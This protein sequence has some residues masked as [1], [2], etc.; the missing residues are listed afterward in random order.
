MTRTRPC[1]PTP[2]PP[3]AHLRHE[4]VL[5]DELAV[6]HDHGD[7]PEQRLEALGQLGAAWGRGCGGTPDWA[8]CRQREKACGVPRTR[9]PPTQPPP[10][11]PS[12]QS[13][14]P[15]APAA[16]MYPG[17]MVMN[18]DAPSSSGISTPSAATNVHAATARWLAP[19]LSTY[20]RPR[21]GS[22][23]LRF[24]ASVTHLYCTLHTLST[25]GR[26]R[27][28]QRV[29]CGVGK[30][31]GA[32][33][34]QRACGRRARSTRAGA[35]AVKAGPP[36]PTATAGGTRA[37]WA[38]PQAPGG[39]GPGRGG[40]AGVVRYGC[41]GRAVGVWDGQQLCGTGS[42]NSLHA[43]R[44]LPRLVALHECAALAGL[45]RAVGSLE[46]VKASPGAAG[47]EALEDVPHGAVVHLEGGVRVGAG[48]GWAAV[49]GRPAA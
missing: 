35:Q 20:S 8:P 21:P 47:R 10:T 26:G 49:R 37:V 14:S 9:G 44:R 1:P 18:A 25:W 15:P 28:G 4:H 23:L 16:P 2:P 3:R 27:R 11:A 45:L 34:G 6:G 22:R 39:W 41:V 38:A 31:L 13:P 5:H 46:L 29:G 7:R 32:T 24:W 48:A 30:R 36:V 40:G 17:F 42:N 19:A 33:G 12:P 43:R